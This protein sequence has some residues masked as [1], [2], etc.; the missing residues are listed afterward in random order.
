M[1]LNTELSLL[2]DY[3]ALKEKLENLSNK[4]MKG[5]L[6]SIKYR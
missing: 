1:F 5:T 4:N 2:N 3:N 6:L